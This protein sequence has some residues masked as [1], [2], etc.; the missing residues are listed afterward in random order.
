MT[1]YGLD[2]VCY[3]NMKMKMKMMTAVVR[4]RSCS[5]VAWMLTVNPMLR[6]KGFFVSFY[7]K[8]E[9]QN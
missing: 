4:M 2:S 5:K 3:M 8:Q 1:A 7:N 9:V 6:M